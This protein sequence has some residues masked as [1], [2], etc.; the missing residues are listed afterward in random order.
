LAAASGGK[1]GGPEKAVANWDEDAVTMAVAAAIDCLKGVDRA[2]VD[3]VL[4]ASTSYPFKEKQGAAIVARALDL[5]RDVMTADLGDSLRAGTNALRAAADAVK[6]GSA[7]RVLVVVGETRMAA[8]R[9][10]MEAQIGDGAAA[11]LIG[12]ADV[13]VGMTAAHAVSDEIIDVWR[14]EGDPFVH[15]WEDRFV[16]DHGYRVNVREVVRGLLA[17]TGLGPKD[18][19]RVVLYGPDAR[20][21]ATVAKELGLDPA[22]VQDAL[23]G[24]VGNV[25]AAFAP[26]L[27]A[28]ALEQAK[29]GERILLVGYGDGA[30]AFVLETTPQVERMEGR[31]GVGWH[32][33]RRADLPSYD[34]YLRFRQLLATEHDRRAGAGLS[35]TK[36]FRDR[37]SDVTLLAQ[38]CRRCGQAQFPHQR[39]CFKCFAKDEFDHVR[40][41]D[42]IGTVKSFTFDNFAGSPNPPLVAGIV[43]V[44]GARLYVQMTDVSPKEVKLGMPVELTFRKIHEA[45]GTPNYFWKSTPVR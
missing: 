40:L 17:K 38:K 11:F 20:S 37:D 34:M 29:A 45:G 13:A 32:L 24:K 21:H 7:K 43:D 1:A 41:S 42:K 30:D 22:T 2:S 18:F 33:A 9:T 12:D 23:F 4:F 8:P 28:A 26:L 16:V 6:A 31:R 15:S 14:T 3:G 19:A 10:A 36:H 27:L 44:E 39:V 35:A 25:G 5:R